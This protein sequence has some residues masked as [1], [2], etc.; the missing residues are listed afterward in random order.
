LVKNDSDEKERKDDLKNRER[1]SDQMCVCYH[2]AD[3]E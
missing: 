1:Y 2:G 3:E